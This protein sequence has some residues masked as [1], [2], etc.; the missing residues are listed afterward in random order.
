MQ[1]GRRLSPVILDM[2]DIEHRVLIRRV[3]S[4][5][6]YP[7][8]QAKLL[9]VPALFRLE[10]RAAAASRLALV[11]SETDRAYL[12]RLGFGDKVQ[13]APNS[14]PVP[15]APPAL[16]GDRTVL[17]LGDMAYP[18]DRLAAERMAR[19]I[20]PLI[21]AR[22]PDAR[23]LVA[24]K[25]S[26]SLPAASA[27]L[28]G[29][30]FL[31]FVA[32]LD[33]LYAGSRAVCCPITVGGGT[34]L[35]LVE[36]ASYARPIVSTRLGAEGLGLTDGRDALLRDDNAGFAEACITLLRDDALSLRLGEAARVMMKA[37]YDVLQVEDRIAQMVLDVIGRGTS[38][39]KGLCSDGHVVKEASAA[40]L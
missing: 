17:F 37:A 6:F 35:K 2:D 9:Q 22:V 33:G 30:E 26:D 15:P 16:V 4:K 5:P 25:A 29:V 3:F 28:P 34:R 21:R 20:W 1:S 10:R 32:D 12:R 27:G 38:Q 18:P 24:G 36:A 19:Q 39:P 7:G 14:L 23:L 40:L 11:C 31:G 8:E 13:V